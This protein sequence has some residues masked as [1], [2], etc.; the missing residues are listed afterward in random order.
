MMETVSFRVAAFG[1]GSYTI[2]GD[3]DGPAHALAAMHE[4]LH[5]I[6]RRS[7]VFGSILRIVQ[8]TLATSAAE[9]DQAFLY[10]LASRGRTSEEVFATYGAFLDA[11]GHSAVG[12]AAADRAIRE[13]PGYAVYAAIGEE[14]VGQQPLAVARVV[15]E[16][17]VR[18]LW[19]SR[20]LP[21]IESVAADYTLLRAVRPQAFPD[22][23]LA[24]LRQTWTPAIAQA[25]TDA[26]GQD[27]IAL[28][29]RRIPTPRELYQVP[30]DT[31]FILPP[32]AAAE[33][34]K[35]ISQMVMAKA[36]TAEELVGTVFDRLCD[37]FP[38]GP[39]ATPRHEEVMAYATASKKLA[40][41]QARTGS[42]F[43]E[44]L[45]LRPDRQRVRSLH[46]TQVPRKVALF[47]RRRTQFV[48]QL[49]LV[50]GRLP[51]SEMVSYQAWGAALQVH[52]DAPESPL[53]I[54]VLD[55]PVESPAWAAS[56]MRDNALLAIWAS[57]LLA[58]PEPF[59]GL[60]RGRAGVWLI[61][62][63]QPRELVRM[64]RELVP[65]LRAEWI[66]PLR[67]RPAVGAIVA[68]QVGTAG[69][70]DGIVFPGSAT[71]CTGQLVMMLKSELGDNLRGV[72]SALLISEEGHRRHAES[73]FLADWLV[74]TERQLSFVGD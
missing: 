12:A 10:Q 34:N 39:L 18:F 5:G 63:V 3:L 7:T 40:Q 65:E 61:C 26:I 6:V 16:G 66:A 53:D 22:R 57:A 74:R 23:R 64:T 37:A 35:V 42:E 55:T 72:G 17:I 43:P 27:A 70:I 54:H 30:D 48:E 69:A 25:C 20:D 28:L 38:T 1:A 33:A 8:H 67:S 50:D 68:P 15:L 2:V 9:I 19:S 13:N 24:I 21:L 14:L 52:E 71:V 51:E 29:T 32:D 58:N 59:F 44:I 31:M 47:V 56:V 4:D 46:I 36:I 73:K 49:D 41:G 45:V 60:S 62:D 11:R